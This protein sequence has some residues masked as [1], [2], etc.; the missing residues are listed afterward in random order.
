MNPTL[1]MF[2][3]TLKDIFNVLG[4]VALIAFFGIAI[5][6]KRREDRRK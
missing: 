6:M 3:F 1:A 2:I 5:I 4:A